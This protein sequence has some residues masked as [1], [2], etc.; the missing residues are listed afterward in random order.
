KRA[1]NRGLENPLDREELICATQS[2]ALD[3]LA[4]RGIDPDAAEQL[5]AQLGDDYF[6]RHTASDIAWHTE[7]IIQH[8]NGS[9][10]LVLMRETAQRRV[11]GDTHIAIYAS[12]QYVLF[13]INGAAMAKLNLI[14]HTARIITSRSLLVLNSYIVLIADGERVLDKP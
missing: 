12:D 2:A 4:Q 1:L 14:I 6:L 3:L 9:D 13:A 7:A 8:P 10:P 5:W 11:H